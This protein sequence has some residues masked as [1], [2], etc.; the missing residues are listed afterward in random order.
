MAGY[1]QGLVLGLVVLGVGI[2]VFFRP[3]NTATDTVVLPVSV[4]EAV[5]ATAPAIVPA[6][7]VVSAL[8]S[9]TS[10]KTAALSATAVATPVARAPSAFDTLPLDTQIEIR[11]LASRDNSD[12]VV[13]QVS[14]TV[15]RA[16]LLGIHQTV[17]VAI[18]GPDGKV[19]IHEF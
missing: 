1:K 2:G 12:V 19:T 11:S 18:I 4:N 10:P 14:P 3:S 16:S 13:E 8:A 9:P 15:F 7:A 5:P 6:Q 17:P